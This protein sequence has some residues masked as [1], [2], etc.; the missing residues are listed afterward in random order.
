MTLNDATVNSIASEPEDTQ[1]ERARTIRKQNSLRIAHTALRTL[2]LASRTNGHEPQSITASDD[3]DE[4]PLEGSEIFDN[5]RTLELGA[6]AV[7]LS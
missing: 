4:S 2:S 7:E 6:E 3:D 1:Q 5:E